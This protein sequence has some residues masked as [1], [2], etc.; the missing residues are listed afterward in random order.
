[1]VKKSNLRQKLFKIIIRIQRSLDVNII[2]TRYRKSEIEMNA[3]ELKQEKN[4]VRISIR[5]SSTKAERDA[6]HNEINSHASPKFLKE[7]EDLFK[8]PVIVSSLLPKK[9]ESNK[10][11]N[12]SY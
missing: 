5:N 8:K 9:S 10:G 2:N 6:A 4:P 3:Q 1:M 12:K 7:V 11:K